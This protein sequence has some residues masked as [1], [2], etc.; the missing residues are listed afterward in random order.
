MAQYDI[1]LVQLLT[2]AKKSMEICNGWSKSLLLLAG[3]HSSLYWRLYTIR[4]SQ[5]RP[6]W[7]VV[8]GN[9]FWLSNKAPLESLEAISRSFSICIGNFLHPF[10]IHR[11]ESVLQQKLIH[12]KRCFRKILTCTE[13]DLSTEDY[14]GMAWCRNRLTSKRAWQCFS[15]R[16]PQNPKGHL[17]GEYHGTIPFFAGFS[18]LVKDPKFIQMC[19]YCTVFVHLVLCLKRSQIAWIAL[20]QCAELPNVCP[21]ESRLVSKAILQ[22][23]E[24][25][26]L[27]AASLIVLVLVVIIDHFRCV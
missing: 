9:I 17:Y 5:F 8:R 21:A 2:R 10:S 15:R 26:N 6:V 1:H 25:R 13:T 22:C 18:K 16:H 11:I 23:A 12:G 7:Q 27:S 24:W 14:W 19:I 4:H 20:A 3:T